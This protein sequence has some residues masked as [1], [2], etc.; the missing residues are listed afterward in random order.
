M[1]RCI[2]RFRFPVFIALSLVINASILN[3]T[4]LP[5]GN[6]PKLV[7]AHFMVGNTFPYNVDNWKK[8]MQ[9]ASSKGI[10]AFALNMGRDDWQPSRVAD[11]YRAAS[12]SNFKLF[13]SFDMASI[14]CNS[15]GDGNLIR[16][17]VRQYNRHPNQLMYEGK[18][19]VS[20]FG[21][22]FCRFGTGSLNEGWHNVLKRD[23]PPV[24]FVP[25][26][27]MQPPEL[28]RL[29]ALD[30]AFSWDSAWPLG[31][32]DINSSND[33]Q[34]QKYLKGRTYMASVSPWF[35]THYSRE[36]YN[37]NWIYRPD[38]WLYASRWELLVKNRKNI[39]LVE[40]ITWNDYGESHYI[41]PIEG[42]QPH[43]ESW[44]NGFDHRGWLDL[45]QYYITA[46]KTGNY[47]SI[48]KDRVFLWGRLYPKNANT[49]D[50][51]GRPDHSEW[52]EDMLWGV[53][54]LTH[55]SHFEMTCG[56]SRYS[57]DLPAGASKVKMPL[58]DDC[59]VKAVVTRDKKKTVDFAPAG[60]HFSKNAP[61]YNFNAFVAASPE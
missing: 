3:A 33:A 11:A 55:P 21:G 41:G 15:D 44:T 35:F 39:D 40:I 46:F 31:N 45:A 61:F 12:G 59:N 36:T 25:A 26:L 8:D 37:K 10:D 16:Q 17:L 14:P 4:V 58:R 6:A 9:L 54:F 28:E 7:F 27:F 32:Y 29:N 42:A 60:F 30:G 5:R 2:L 49:G 51:I 22:Q 18:N 56:G 38:S 1:F 47:P 50:P 23:M 53:V 20:T 57:S 24:H 19:F 13:I 43:S 34:Y 48:K 52:T